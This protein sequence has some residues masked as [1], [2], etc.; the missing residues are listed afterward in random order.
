MISN[1]LPVPKQILRQAREKFFV[2]FCASTKEEYKHLFASSNI[3]FLKETAHQVVNFENR[4][5]VTVTRTENSKIVKQR[6]LDQGWSDEKLFLHCVAHRKIHLLL[7]VPLDPSSWNSVIPAVD[8]YATVS[9]AEF[10][11]NNEQ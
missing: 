4:L 6:D 3:E 2:N 11:N 7:H 5:K 9:L 10:M 8:S 1:N